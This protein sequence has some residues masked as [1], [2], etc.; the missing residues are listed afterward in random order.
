M[1]FLVLKLFKI[2][3]LQKTVQYLVLLLIPLFEILLVQNYATF[4][5]TQESGN[6]HLY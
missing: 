1:F 3:L 2:V 6:V 4:S 5:L